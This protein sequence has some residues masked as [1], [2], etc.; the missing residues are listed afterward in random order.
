MSECLSV[1]EE[2]IRR[3]QK[4]ADTKGRRIDAAI[5]SRVAALVL[6]EVSRVIG[7]KCK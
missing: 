5:V 2:I 7:R 3:V 1:R 4:K 6:D